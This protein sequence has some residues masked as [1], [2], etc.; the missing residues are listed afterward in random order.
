MVH[1]V[2]SCQRGIV[3]NAET[4]TDGRCGVM[5]TRVNQGVPILGFAFN[6][7]ERERDES[8]SPF[9]EERTF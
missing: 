1:G 6:N 2:L 4:D 3:E 8:R 5:S 7:A 9:V